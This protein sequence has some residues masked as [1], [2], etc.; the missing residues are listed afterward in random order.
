MYEI[1]LSRFT[2]EGNVSR[3]SWK[4]LIAALA[5]CGYE[6]YADEEKIV[7]KQGNDDEV[8]EIKTKKEE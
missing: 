3:E 7:F 8:K 5:L 2:G 4:D 1:T 6:L